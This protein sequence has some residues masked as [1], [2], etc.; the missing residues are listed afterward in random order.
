MNQIFTSTNNEFCSSK[1][2]VHQTPNGKGQGLFACA[3]ISKGEILA[4]FGG[5]IKSLEDFLQLPVETRRFSL[6]VEENF[7]LVPLWPPEPAFFFNHSCNPNAGF[8]GQIVLVAMRD[9]QVGEEVCFDYAM[10]ESA[11][12]DEFDCLCG[13]PNC[14][15]RITGND[16][17]RPELW[18]RYQGYF[19][20]YLQRRI[21]F[22]KKGQLSLS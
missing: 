3:P 20:P 1:L 17:Q 22:L 13:A 16:W 21:D 8:S 9:I 4:I 2:Q 11:P 14:R 6:Q 19:S 15:Q 12:Y 7:F 10:S 5:C 18:E